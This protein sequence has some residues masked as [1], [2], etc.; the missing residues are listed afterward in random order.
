MLQSVGLG[1]QNDCPFYPALRPTDVWLKCGAHLGNQ[2]EDGENKENKPQP[3]VLEENGS[4]GR[5][6]MDYNKILVERSGEVVTI[7]FNRPK[8][9]NAIDAEMLGELIDVC[10]KLGLDTDC[11]FVIF[12]GAGN[13]FMAGEDMR[14]ELMCKNGDPISARLKQHQGQEFIRLVY[15]LEQITVAAVHGP[16]LGAGLGLAIACDLRIASQSAIWGLPNTSVGVFFTWGL[17]PRLASLIGP[18]KAKE[19]TLTGDRLSP[20]EALSIGLVNKLVQPEQLMDET[21]QLINRIAG[22]GPLAVRMTKKIVNAA[23]A[24]NFGN[25]STCE[26]EL[27]ERVYMSTE[28]AEGHQ[29][30]LEKRKPQF[31]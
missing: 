14:D 28:P 5:E 26:P 7:V 25:I 10:R 9:Y 6:D 29:A 21:H 1:C 15:E 20:D 30:F 17:L 22:N 31:K 4:L 19:L 13:G 18:A 12:T 24:S 2:G 3:V 23:M 16:C 11:R 8:I 27:V